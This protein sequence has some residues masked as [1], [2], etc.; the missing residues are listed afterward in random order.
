MVTLAIG[1]FITSIE[2]K[3][4][5]LESQLMQNPAGPELRW[6]LFELA[7]LE[8]LLRFTQPQV[9]PRARASPPSSGVHFLC[10]EFNSSAIRV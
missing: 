3:I 6:L 1:I 2:A 5:W 8:W 7:E 10:A 9:E 4:C